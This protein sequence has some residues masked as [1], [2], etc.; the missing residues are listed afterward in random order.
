MRKDCYHPKE[1][2]SYLMTIG[3]DGTALAKEHLKAAIHH[4]IKQ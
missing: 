4:M 3:F 1:N 2:S